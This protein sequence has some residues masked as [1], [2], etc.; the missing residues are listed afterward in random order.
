MERRLNNIK[1]DSFH[2]LMIIIYPLI[3][4][5]TPKE[6]LNFIDNL[7]REMLR[8]LVKNPK[9]SNRMNLLEAILQDLG[10]YRKKREGK[11]IFDNIFKKIGMEYFD[12]LMT[13]IIDTEGYINLPALEALVQIEGEKTKDFL[14][15]TRH[16]FRFGF[17]SDVLWDFQNIL[18]ALLQ[19]FNPEELMTFLEENHRDD[20]FNIVFP[21][22]GIF[23]SL[24]MSTQKRINMKQFITAF[25]LEE[26]GGDFYLEN[27]EKLGLFLTDI[28]LSEIIDINNEINEQII[29]TL[30]WVG[31]GATGKLYKKLNKLS[32][33][34]DIE[35]YRD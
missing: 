27:F 19:C 25:L 9:E 20:L 14:I 4:E 15:N 34:Y 29:K 28:M 8:N 17:R 2:E 5:M 33:K 24:K 26:E 16:R 11:D 22:M 13:I 10:N 12:Y 31:E 3:N 30:E 6:F 1:F 18:N 21:K 7:N 32:E 35:K 23:E